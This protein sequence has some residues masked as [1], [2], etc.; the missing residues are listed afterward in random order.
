MIPRTE[1]LGTL[2]VKSRESPRQLVPAQNNFLYRLKK[3]REMK[4]Q[5]NEQQHIMCEYMSMMKI[6]RS[7]YKTQMYTVTGRTQGCKACK[8]RDRTSVVV[9]VKVDLDC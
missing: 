1:S 4:E 6:R 2:N 3:K 9:V 7:N 5:T 8:G